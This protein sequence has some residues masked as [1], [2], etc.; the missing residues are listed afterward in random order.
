[1]SAVV[2]LAAALL[3]AAEKD[4]NDERL[5]R[6]AALRGSAAVEEQDE[7]L[8]L[9]RDVLAD[10]K[11]SRAQ[12]F[13][14][15][16]T[17]VDVVWRRRRDVPAALAVL[18]EMRAFYPGDAE[19]DRTAVF[20][21]A[22]VLWESG[23]ELDQGVPLLT[24]LAARAA[25]D[26]AT[27]AQARLRLARFLVRLR[28]FD[29]AYASA[30]QAI[31]LA[32]DD[33]D[34]AAA[35]LWEMQGAAEGMKDP[36]RRYEV[37]RRA[38]EPRY[39]DRLDAWAR[40]A[41]QAAYGRVLLATQ[42]LDE[43][44]ALFGPLEQADPDPAHRQEWC[45]LLAEALLQQERFD[46][47][48][49]AFEQVIS[50]HPAVHQQWWNA[51]TRIVDILRRQ[52]RL[53]EALQ[54]TRVL[55]DAAWDQNTLTQ[56]SEQAVALLVAIDDLPERANL[57]IAWQTY[58]PAG[59]DGTPG[60]PDDSTDPLAACPYPDLAA[61]AAAFDR[62]SA[63]L[64]DTV[65]A[66]RQRARMAL[67]CGKPRDALAQLADAMA[68]RG[69]EDP[70]W[71]CSEL[72]QQTLRAVVGHP[73]RTAEFC[74]FIAWGPAGPDLTP[75]TADDLPDPLAEFALPSLP[76]AGGLARL[77]AEEVTA[78]EQLGTALQPLLANPA[79]PRWRRTACARG[80][81]RV[82][83]AL[84]S[85]QAGP[86]RDL[87]LET[88]L[89]TDDREL[90]R[91]C[92]SLAARCAK[93]RD[94]HAGALHTFAKQVEADCLARGVTLGEGVAD[95]LPKHLERLTT[96][97]LRQ[98]P[99][100]PRLRPIPVIAGENPPL[101]ARSPAAPAPGL[102]VACYEVDPK[103]KLRALPDFGT[104]APGRE[105]T[106]ESV[107]ARPA[108]RGEHVA[109]RFTGYILVPRSTGY[110]FHLRSKDGSRL[111]IGETEVVNHDGTHGA[112][113]RAGVVNLKAGYHP[114]TVL[115]FCG[116]GA[117]EVRL[118]WESYGIPKQEVPPAALFHDGP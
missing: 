35:A 97:L 47:A 113:E 57:F 94:L 95:L 40:Y 1:L 16:A 61:R 49:P 100:V 20:R 106:A 7:A 52:Q 18:N 74:S 64:G 108:S 36:E 50:G 70:D 58:G 102:Q 41:R 25:A 33:A 65:V 93:G 6:A 62:A 73:W 77:S 66:A 116:Q 55:L 22:D 34:L 71:I 105:T 37:L 29:E 38:L 3:P 79:E 59:K 67:Y 109:L 104:L 56:A 90:A 91:A 111:L 78:L 110:R 118:N 92:L 54:A 48:L 85:W 72:V 5:V 96:N 23:K 89:T 101:A 17:R 68:R 12:Q 27:V 28:R 117:P 51:Q 112:N 69:I 82:Q 14:A 99:S 24:D 80:L 2:L 63:D 88:A 103:A 26:R 46:A 81:D 75:G 60:T 44:R 11:A 15:F 32:P 31:E 8:R 42:R 114:L 10:P 21:A 4:P 9:C 43:L 107:S 76:T 98:K 39:A 13:S 115:Y 84:A 30:A 87:A 83:E 45:L 53:P 86:L 19:A